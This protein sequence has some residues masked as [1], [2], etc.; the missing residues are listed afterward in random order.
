M[1]GRAVS[2]MLGWTLWQGGS[3]MTL[4]L[5]AP[6]PATTVRE[7]WIWTC[8]HRTSQEPGVT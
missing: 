4:V 5:P 3:G 7:G 2:F 8:S 6:A 1:A